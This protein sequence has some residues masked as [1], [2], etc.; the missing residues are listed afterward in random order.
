ME[1]E[2]G[3]EDATGAGADR[4]RSA[5]TR[6]MPPATPTVN[7]MIG[8]SPWAARLHSPSPTKTPSPTVLLPHVGDEQSGQGEEPN[9]VD[10]PGHHR[11]RE[12]D[13]VGGPRDLDVGGARVINPVLAE[14]R[15]AGSRS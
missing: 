6:A 10:V 1:R 11:Q 7:T 9:G 3:A 8:T 13:A 4:R 12:S 5:S 15:S 14:L 2:E